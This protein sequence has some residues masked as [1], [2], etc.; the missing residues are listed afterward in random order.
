MQPILCS[1]IP[2]RKSFSVRLQS[3]H[4]TKTPFAIYCSGQLPTGLDGKVVKGTMKD[5]TRAC[6]SNLKDV[7]TAADSSLDKIVKVQIFLTRMKDFAEMNEEYVQWIKH[8]PARSCV[9]VKQLPKGV[10]IEIECV[11]LP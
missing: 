5:M 1:K 8:A 10:D 3:S 2:A 7:L 9:A 11:A 6:L 4:A